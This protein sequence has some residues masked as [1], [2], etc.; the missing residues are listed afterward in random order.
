MHRVSSWHPFNHR[1]LRSDTQH[2]AVWHFLPNSPRLLRLTGR[3]MVAAR[4]REQEFSPSLTY[5]WRTWK[6]KPLESACSSGVEKKKKEASVKS[7]DLVRPET[8]AVEV[9]VSSCGVYGILVKVFGNI[10]RRR[11]WKQPVNT[12]PEETHKKSKISIIMDY[13]FTVQTVKI[14]IYLCLYNFIFLTFLPAPPGLSDPE[15]SSSPSMQCQRQPRSLWHNPY[16]SA[17]RAAQN[18]EETKWNVLNQ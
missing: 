15:P 10:F 12:L 5:R 2:T 9:G 6:L 13:T 7:S 11:L 8:W 14:F 17:K 4:S 16:P 18:K 1:S 3:R